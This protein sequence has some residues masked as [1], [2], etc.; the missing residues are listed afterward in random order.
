MHK[1]ICIASIIFISLTSEACRKKPSGQ[2]DSDSGV[3]KATDSEA[4]AAPTA[5]AAPFSLP[6]PPKKKWSD[7][8]PAEKTDQIEFW[9][10]EH[11]RGDAALKGKILTEIRA[12]GLSKMERAELEATRQRFGFGP[13]PPF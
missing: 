2:P 3:A 13:L 1:V 12:A 7:K 6:E 11:Q 10:H 9:L 5:P 4:T 8:T